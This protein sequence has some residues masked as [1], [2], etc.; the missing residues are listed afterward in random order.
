MIPALN[1]LK[2]AYKSAVLVLDK[3]DWGFTGKTVAYYERALNAAVLDLYRGGDA[4]DFIDKAIYLIEEQF[5]RAWR[6]GA[7][8]VGFDPAKIS[9]GE[10]EFLQSR[11]DREKEYILDFA[12]AIENAREAGDPVKPLQERV[13]LW[14]NRYEE[15]RDTARAHYG[16]QTGA[17]L[18]WRVGPTEH[19][20]TCLALD[21]VVA[22]ADDWE[23]ARGRGIYP[24]SPDLDCHGYNCQC[25]LDPTDDPADEGGIPV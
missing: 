12:Q 3:T 25:S 16:I 4:G 17:R 20:D 1:H 22:T 15:V 23:E 24:K 5:G 21:G 18:V 13:P 19:C 11:M 14:A 9:E 8:D 2:Q 7:R 6:E 10:L